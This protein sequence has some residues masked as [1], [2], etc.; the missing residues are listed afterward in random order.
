M[1]WATDGAAAAAKLSQSD[2]TSRQLAADV[3]RDVRSDAIYLAGAS[4][5]HRTCFVLCR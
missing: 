1:F 3:T 5:V 2:M 4:V